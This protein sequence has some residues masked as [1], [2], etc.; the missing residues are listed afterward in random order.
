MTSQAEQRRAAELQRNRAQ[1]STANLGEEEDDDDDDDDDIAATAG[2]EP[3][4][5]TAKPACLAHDRWWDQAARTVQQSGRCTHPSDTHRT[6]GHGRV[7][8]ARAVRGGAKL[9]VY[10]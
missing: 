5:R 1:A 8:T 4:V 10:A 7:R 2:G 6:K 9:A 3:Y